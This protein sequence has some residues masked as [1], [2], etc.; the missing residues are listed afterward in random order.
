MGEDANDLE[1]KHRPVWLQRVTADQEG[2]EEQLEREAEAPLGRILH[3]V[4]RGV[5]FAYGV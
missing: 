2:H 4:G 1:T 5:N 3:P